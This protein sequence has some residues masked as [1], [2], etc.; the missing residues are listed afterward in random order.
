MRGEPQIPKAA[1][2]TPV[3]MWV[4]TPVELHIPL[5]TQAAAQFDELGEPLKGAAT[6]RRAELHDVRGR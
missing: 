3:E 2:E 1:V 4:I 5:L 6:A